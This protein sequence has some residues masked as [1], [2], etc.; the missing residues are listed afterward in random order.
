[1]DEKEVVKR[2]LYQAIAYFIERQQLVAQAMLDLGLDVELVGTYG[3]LAWIS[4]ED[5]PNDFNGFEE[6]LEEENLPQEERRLINALKHNSE[7][8]VS[9]KGLWGANGEWEYSLHGIGCCLTNRYT[10]EPIDWDCPNVMAFQTYFFGFHLEWQLRSPIRSDMLK[11]TRS[12][13]RKRGRKSIETL[14]DEMI[15]EGLIEQ[16]RTLDGQMY[17]LADKY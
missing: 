12:W 9:R 5:Y 13:I 3:G 1:M 10:R 2:E 17:V 16:D 14:I 7:N 6:L 15:D 8:H 4:L 11:H